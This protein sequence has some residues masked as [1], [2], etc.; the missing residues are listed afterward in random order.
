MWPKSIIDEN[1]LILRLQEVIIDRA[2]MRPG[3][4]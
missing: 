3:K 4:V 2:E 1:R